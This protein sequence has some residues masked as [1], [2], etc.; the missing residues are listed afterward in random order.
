MTKCAGEEVG[1]V[2]LNGVRASITIVHIG[3]FFQN[4][5]EYRL[6]QLKGRS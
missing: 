6:I 1:E 3:N 4:E 5:Y 2:R